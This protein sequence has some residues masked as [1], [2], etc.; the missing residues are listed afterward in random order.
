[1]AKCKNG[2]MRKFMYGSVRSGSRKVGTNKC[3]RIR[4]M[5]KK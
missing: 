3:R 1:M 4:G 2:N 5:K